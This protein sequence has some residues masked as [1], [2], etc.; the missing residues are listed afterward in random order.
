MRIL[1][2]NPNSTS[3]MTKHV[4]EQLQT[5]LGSTSE[6]VQLTAAHGAPV[7][8]TNQAFAEAAETAHEMLRQAITQGVIFDK[9]LLACFGD[10]GLESMQHLTDKPVVGLAQASMQVAERFGKPYAIV[11]AGAPWESILLQRFR[12]W[13]SS[14]L[15]R[16][17]YVISGTGLDVF[18]TP[19]ATIPAVQQ[20]ISEGQNNGAENIILGGAVFAGFGTLMGKNSG[21][22][23]GIIDCARSAAYLLS[24]AENLIP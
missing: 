18:H 8:A 24:D 10:P 22:S 14:P 19:L 3:A 13:G 6:L 17:V 7:I 21:H 15:F 12:H 1:V 4:A 16:G 11:T 20:A 9:V 5:H 2:I 23:E